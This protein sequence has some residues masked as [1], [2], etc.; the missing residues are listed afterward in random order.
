M[1]IESRGQN[2]RDNNRGSQLLLFSGTCKI[3]DRHVRV[4]LFFIG[5]ENGHNHSVVVELHLL[6]CIKI[7]AD[8]SAPFDIKHLAKSLME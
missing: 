6:V 5:G 4:T 7:G 8:N 3:V 1:V 2:S